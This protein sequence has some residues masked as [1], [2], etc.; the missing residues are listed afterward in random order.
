MAGYGGGG[1]SKAAPTN[2]NEPHF[3]D[4]EF[5]AV[6][7]TRIRAVTELIAKQTGKNAAQI[8]HSFQHAVPHCFPAHSHGAANKSAAGSGGSS[9]AVPL[10]SIRPAPKSLTALVDHTILKADASAKD[11]DLI[12]AEACEFGFAAVC[13]NP[14]RIATVAKAL[15]ANKSG[16]KVCH[17]QS[18]TAHDLVLCAL[19]QIGVAAVV[20]FPLGANTTAIKA[21]ETK[22]LI[23]K[24]N[25]SEI[26]M[27]LNVGALKERDYALVFKEISALASLCRAKKKILKV[28]FECSL[29][30]AE[31][32]ID[33]CL[34]SVLARAHYVKTCKRQLRPSF[35]TRLMSRVL[36]M[37]RCSDR[38]W[39][40]RCTCSGCAADEAGGGRF[41]I[42]E[43]KWWDQG[44]CKCKGN[45]RCRSQPHRHECR[46]CDRET[47]ALACKRDCTRIKTLTHSNVQHTLL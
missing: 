9:A 24:Y 42:G 13:V 18:I 4:A 20:G 27:V 22:E 7:Q 43:S 5:P 37:I 29:L 12:C 36:V 1:D 3:S 46:C 28:I 17:L 15:N 35:R 34:I 21:T 26:D 38:F 47:R 33:A 39:R 32:M 44:L 45:G 6:I 10:Y 8:Y 23:D 41:C 30:T 14:S 25:V 40:V 2:L 11:V 19:S 16:K 31:E